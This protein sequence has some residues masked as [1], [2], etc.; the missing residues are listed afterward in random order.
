MHRRLTVGTVA[1]AIGLAV[2]VGVGAQA[3]SRAPD[4]PL[5]RTGASTPRTAWGDPDISGMWSTDD[6]RGIPVQRPDEFGNRAEL[7]DAEYAK[8]VAA[9]DDARTRELN[10]VGAFRND[11][12]TRTLRLTSLVVAPVNGKLPPLTPEARREVERRQAAAQQ[13][14]GV[15]DRPQLVRSLHHPRHLR[16]GAPRH[17]RQRQL[18]LPVAWLRDHHL[19]DG[20]RHAHHPARRPAAH[21]RRHHASTWATRAATS[22]ATRS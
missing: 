1:G 6:L 8:R 16:L 11:V 18:H 5:S 15:V 13:S 12:G 14:P 10:R 20:P 2:S 17:L 4:A 19:R 21:R 3:P 22:K 7:T 9:N